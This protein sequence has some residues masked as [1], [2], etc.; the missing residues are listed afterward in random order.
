M[1]S[2]LKITGY[3][4]GST[5]GNLRL[6]SAMW[7]NRLQKQATRMG[8]GVAIFLYNLAILL[9]L[10][11]AV[12][13]LAVQLLVHRRYRESLL[14]RLGFLSRS[15]GEDKRATGLPCT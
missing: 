3:T 11:V 9:I 4:A 6:G 5:R 13:Y 12:A 15:L 1:R 8:G 2:C 14:P 7:A 10:P